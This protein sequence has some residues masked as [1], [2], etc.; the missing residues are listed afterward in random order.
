M[1]SQLN[2]LYRIGL[3]NMNYEAHKYKTFS[4]LL[5]D[6]TSRINIRA[7]SSLYYIQAS[8][9]SILWES[10]TKFHTHKN[11]VKPE[12]THIITNNN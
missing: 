10:E 1:S 2:V 5:L 11:T 8:S 12:A 9:V 4:I 6:P 7:C 3:T